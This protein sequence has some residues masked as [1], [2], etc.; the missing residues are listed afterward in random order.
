MN[1]KLN[2]RLNA[3]LRTYNSRT[4]L[5]SKIN[6]SNFYRFYTFKNSVITRKDKK[7]LFKPNKGKDTNN[8]II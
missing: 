2:K 5:G 1:N 4:L 3:K 6:I 8:L 7:Y